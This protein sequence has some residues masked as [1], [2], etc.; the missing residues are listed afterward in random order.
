MLTVCADHPPG[1]LLSFSCGHVFHL[2][3]LL[4]QVFPPGTPLP[5]MLTQFIDPV[6]AEDEEWEIPPLDRSIG[7]KVDRAKLLGTVLEGGCPLEGKEG[8]G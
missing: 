6:A 5:A 8:D 1:Y 4:S 7:P 2:S 3:C